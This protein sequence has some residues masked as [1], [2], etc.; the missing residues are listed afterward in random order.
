MIFKFLLFLAY[1]FVKS[2][3][4]TAKGVIFSCVNSNF[5]Y[6]NFHGSSKAI[7]LPLKNCGVQ[8]T[9]FYGK[10]RIWN[11]IDIRNQGPKITCID[12]LI[13]KP[14]QFWPIFGSEILNFRTKSEPDP[15][16]DVIFEISDSRNHHFD[17][18]FGTIPFIITV[19]VVCVSPSFRN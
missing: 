2:T 17:I 8:R 19:L 12:T 11:D 3:R 5:I 10:L 4:S 14:L 16:S 9:I 6:Q 15:K 1:R 7:R 18:L 13:L